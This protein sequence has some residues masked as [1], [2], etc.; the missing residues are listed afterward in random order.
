MQIV[1]LQGIVGLQIVGLLHLQ[2]IVDIVVGTEFEEL[3]QKRLVDHVDQIL[4][5]FSLYNFLHIN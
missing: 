1:G 2:D 5:P 3:H 4:W